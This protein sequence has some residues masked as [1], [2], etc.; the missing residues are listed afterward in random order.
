M[1]LANAV[2][3][4]D[5][6]QHTYENAAYAR[7]VMLVNT[8]GD[9]VAAGG[10]G[11]GTSSVYILSGT[12][13]INN[14]PS[15]VTAS[16]QNT[17]SVKPNALKILSWAS[18]DVDAAAVQV[19]FANTNSN[20]TAVSIANAGDERIYLHKTSSVTS[21]SFLKALEYG[22]TWD[23]PLGYTSDTTNDIYA[24]RA[25]AQTNDNVVVTLWGEV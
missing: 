22:E 5:Q 14:F 10:G 18:Y 1:S 4:V 17:A 24:I 12:S 21:N 19:V 13:S 2:H 15:L 11:G 8:A 16:I 6:E 3:P 25:S 7:R 9:Y 20:M 23:F